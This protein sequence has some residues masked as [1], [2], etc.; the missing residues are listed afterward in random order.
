VPP[1]NVQIAQRAL[2][3]DRRLLMPH[4]LTHHVTGDPYMLFA[5]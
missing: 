5:G 3:A 4:I 1:I 2:S